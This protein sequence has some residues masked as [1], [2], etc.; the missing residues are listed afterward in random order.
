MGRG[1]AVVVDEVR[2]LAERTAVLTGEIDQVIRGIN[3]TSRQTT[4]K[5]GGALQL[6]DSGVERSDEAIRAVGLIEHS[7]GAAMSMVTEIAEA[8]REQG[9]TCN[10]IAGK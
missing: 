8:I 7:S 3:D 10:A 5:V 2:K 6:V 1:F 9:G 4:S